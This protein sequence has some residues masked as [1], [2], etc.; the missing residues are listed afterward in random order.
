[1]TDSPYTTILRILAVSSRK[2]ADLQ[3]AMPGYANARIAEI[4]EKMKADG[5]VVTRFRRL[6]LTKQGRAAAPSS[7]P[8][9]AALHGT[10]V[11]PKTLRREGSC[12]RHLPSLRG[13]RLYYYGEQV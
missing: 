5:L 9:L 10:Y 11:P 8:N 13:G 4:V 12:V 3:A 6:E 2:L 1:M 7:A